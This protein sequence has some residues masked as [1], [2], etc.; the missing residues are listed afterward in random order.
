MSD[1][2]KLCKEFE[3]LDPLTFSDTLRVK[4]VKIIA[5]LSAITMDG[6]A[7]TQIYTAFILAAVAADGRLDEKEFNLIR[8]ALEIALESEITYDEA[9]KL[10]REVKK[11]IKDARN[12]LDMM[13]DIL[14]EVSEEL[15]DDIIIVTMLICAV[16][17][18]ITPSEK[19][20]IR[21]LI[22]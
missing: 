9:K 14:G 8:P 5:A 11:D 15:K 16:D 6:M 1:F 20:W 10:L 18:K 21:Q 17:G 7:G 22:E 12:E 19:K 13:V 3:Q 2:D 4:S